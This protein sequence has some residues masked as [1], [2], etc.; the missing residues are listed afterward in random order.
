M[1]RR[2]LL[3]AGAVLAAP[4]VATG[5]GSA[6]TLRF[7][8]QSNLASTDPVWSTAVIVRNH[9]LMIYDTL[10]GLDRS[11]QPRPQMAEGHEVTDN[12]LTWTI[13]LREGLRF[14]DGAPVTARDCVASIRRWSKRDVMGQRLDALADEIA[15]PNDREIRIRLKKPW[16]GLAWAFGKPSANICAIMPERVART[17]PFAQITDNTGSGPYRFRQDLFRPGD[18]AIYERFADYR[19]REEPSDFLA[20]GK[21]VHFDRVEWRILPDPATAAAA[22]Q[23]N[24]ADWWETPLA[25]LLPQLS[26]NRDIAVD[27]INEAG[28]LGVLRFNF[29]HPPFD[30]PAVRRALLP[31]L[32][33]RAFMDAAIG[34]DRA[35]SRVPCGVFTPGTP[36]AN[37][38][39]LDVLTGPRDLA[40]AQRALRE[41]GYRNERVVLMSATDLPVLQNLTEVAADLLRRVGFN[42]DNPAMDWGTQIQRRTN[43]GP[44][45]AG[46]WSAFCTTWE[47]LDMSVPGSSQPLRGNGANAWSGWPTFPR[48]EELRE[49]WFDA[50]DLPAQRRIAEEMQREAL[51]EVAFL[52]LGLVLPRQAYRRSLTGVVKGGPA[53]FWGVRRA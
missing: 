13:R 42:V 22:L 39:G 32:D 10:F 29:L 5:Q 53:L 33:Q 47:G 12:G 44:V 19:T 1:K 3:A 52:P 24:E 14:H 23:R 37:D 26:R 38:S 16:P 40:A 36:L 35:M 28:N 50:P 20:G 34:T 46:G 31:A 41:S 11:F 8:P 17:D 15:A 21:P 25:D 30:N 49:A 4:G 6:R 27:L 2:S 43:R 7:I 48:L 9:G 51:R 18:V 45:E